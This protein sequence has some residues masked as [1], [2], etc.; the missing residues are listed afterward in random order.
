MSIR[1]LGRWCAFLVLGTFCCVSALA[2]QESPKTERVRIGDREVAIP[3][4]FQYCD[5]DAADERDKLLIDALD[6]LAA[7]RQ[8]LRRMAPCDELKAW[9]KDRDADP[10]EVMQ[11]LHD[12]AAGAT[13]RGR[14]AYLT[15]VVAGR[16]IA[17]RSA[18]LKKATDGPPSGTG[19][20]L[21]GHIGLMERSDQAVMSADAVV[22]VI[23][24]QQHEMASLRAWTL[25]AGQSIVIEVVVPYDGDGSALDWMYAD[26]RDHVDRLLSA[27]GERARR[28]D[29]TRPPILTQPDPKPR[30]PPPILKPRIRDPD[31]E[32]FFAD[33]GGQIALWMIAGGA[34][35]IIGSM[36]WSRRVR[37]PA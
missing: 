18:T 35:L 34:A 7:N 15:A 37:R 14:A 16:P 28:F 26:Q 4:P 12:P 19:E 5:L 31:E 20:Y 24:G 25:A 11:M 22:V 3:A 13:D 6:K 29:S 21:Y 36:F 30:K 23:D 1:R 8:V 9:R 2:Q 27:N 32:E 33:Y 10:V 17:G